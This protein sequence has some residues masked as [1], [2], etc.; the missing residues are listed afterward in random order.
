MHADPIFAQAA[1]NRKV[2]ALAEF[3][4]G[5]QPLLSQFALSIKDQ[6]KPG[7]PLLPPLHSDQFWV[8]APFPEHNQLLTCC[9][10][11]DGDYTAES[12]STHVVPGSHR[13]RR[14]PT[15][16]EEKHSR[17]LL[18]P[19]SGPRGCVVCW[20]GSVWH[21]GGVRT[22][23]GQRIVAH[24]TYC[25]IA[26]R[27]LERYDGLLPQETISANPLLKQLMG[28]TTDNF[29]ENTPKRPFSFLSFERL[30]RIS[31]STYDKEGFKK[32]L[33]EYAKEFLKRNPSALKTFMKE[34]MKK[35]QDRSKL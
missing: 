15:K 25:R 24:V 19:T 28:S 7:D 29:F 4:C 21:S 13:L 1:C 23:P 27:P 34:N 31:Q 26:M 35:L 16:N 8:P 22:I 20:D 11:L 3:M 2:H 5:Q 9:W 6:G 18:E 17:E 14:H 12:G 10:A 33:A 32:E 30:K